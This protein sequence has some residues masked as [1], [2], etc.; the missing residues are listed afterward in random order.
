[1]PI[2]VQDTSTALLL[3][4][5]LSA[6]GVAEKAPKEWCSRGGPRPSGG[7]RLRKIDRRDRRVYKNVEAHRRERRR[8]VEI[9]GEAPMAPTPWTDS[10]R[11]RSAVAAGRSTRP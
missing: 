1:M 11:P 4:A 2:C 6:I 8:S 5:S 9:P 7:Y 10:S 3:H